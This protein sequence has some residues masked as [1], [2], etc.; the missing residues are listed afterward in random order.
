MDRLIADD[1]PIHKVG[2]LPTV[3]G[4]QSEPIPSGITSAGDAGLAADLGA[5]DGRHVKSQSVRVCL[6]LKDH[7]HSSEP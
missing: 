3:H 6:L 1:L 4:Q 5:A 7:I 2:T